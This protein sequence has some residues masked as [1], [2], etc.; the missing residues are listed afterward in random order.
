MEAITGA[1]KGNFTMM[2]NLG[3]AMN[4]TNLQVYALSKGI[5]KSYTAMTQAEKVQLA[6]NMFLEQTS[7]YAGN[8]AKEKKTKSGAKT[9]TKAQT[10][11]YKKTKK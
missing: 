11:T 8:Y 2:D 7:E 5:K 1:A 10:T 6:Y 4:A 3:V 9:K